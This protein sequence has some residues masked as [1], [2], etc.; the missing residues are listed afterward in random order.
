MYTST[1]ITAL[2]AQEFVEQFKSVLNDAACRELTN[3]V[4]VWR[5]AEPI[6]RV[7]GESPILYIGQTR[8]SLRGRYHNKRAL[9]IEVANFAR[10][11]SYIIQRYGPIFIQIIE[12]ANP[13]LEEWQQLSDYFSRHLEYPPLNRSVPGKPV[14]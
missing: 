3:I 11:F 10:A 8:Q 13:K 4:Y 6:T 2:T 5:T 9:D 7:K 1:P 14:D 12:A